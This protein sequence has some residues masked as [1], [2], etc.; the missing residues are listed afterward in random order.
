MKFNINVLSVEQATKTSANG[1]AYQ[2]LDVTFKNLDSGK[3]D[4]K[5]IMSFSEAAFKALAGAKQGDLFLIESNK[6][7]KTGYW[8][9]T[10]VSPQAP[11]SVS[12]VTSDN[13]KPG[14]TPT[15]KSNYET[16]EER[17]KKQVYIIRQSSLSAAIASLSV[18][19]K[20]P[21]KKEEVA[22]LAQFYVDFV[23]QEAKPTL[24]PLAEMTDD[25]P[26]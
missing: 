21:L 10:G 7:E 16:P 23:F 12:A 1:K 3:V 20:A 8:D 4:A 18:G 9:W 6:N 13:V 15:P 2:Q 19:A 22:E 17:A 26:Y 5:K 24:T 14:F 11:G 25:V